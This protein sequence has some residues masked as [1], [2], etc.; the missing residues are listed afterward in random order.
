MGVSCHQGDSSD[1]DPG[2]SFI[3]HLTAG[4]AL[5]PSCDPHTIIAPVLCFHELSTARRI[6]CNPGCLDLCV[7][8]SDPPLAVSD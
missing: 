4:I 1:D 5:G 3:L 2:R 7:Q 8:P 6:G